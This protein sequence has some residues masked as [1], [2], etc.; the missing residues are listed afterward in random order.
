MSEASPISEIQFEQFIK[1]LQHVSTLKMVHQ[2]SQVYTTVKLDFISERVVFYDFGDV[3]RLL[4]DAVRNAHLQIRIDHRNKVVKC[5]SHTTESENVKNHLSL[6][7]QGLNEAVCMIHK[8]SV[9]QAKQDRKTKAIEEMKAQVES[10]HKRILAR[11]VIIERRKEEY[12]QMLQEKEREEENKR[13][14]LERVRAEEEKKRLQ[15]ESAKREEER[16][17]REMEDQEL[18]ETRA[19]MEAARSRG[20]AFKEGEKVDKVPPLSPA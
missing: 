10:E 6:L 20:K 14:E 15:N 16:I 9:D 3:E 18:E 7:A 13:L 2:I 1:Q 5:G 12:E 17:R 4:V 19:L 11:K 8:G